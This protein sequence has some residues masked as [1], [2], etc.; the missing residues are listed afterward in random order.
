VGGNY[1]KEKDTV[2]LITEFTKVFLL[3]PYNTFICCL[4]TE[5]ENITIF[6][7][8]DLISNWVEELKCHSYCLTEIMRV[9]TSACLS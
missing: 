4:N 6:P 8:P 5:L 1:S 3:F 9:V 2:Y 7:Q